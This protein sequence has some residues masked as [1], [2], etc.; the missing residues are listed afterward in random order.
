MMLLWYKD[1]YLISADVTIVKYHIIQ[2]DVLYEIMI[3]KFDN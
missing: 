2:Y 1:H 3:L